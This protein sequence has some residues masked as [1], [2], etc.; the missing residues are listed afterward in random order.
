MRNWKKVLAYLILCAGAFVTFALLA[1]GRGLIVAVPGI[2]M[3]VFAVA[4]LRFM[5]LREERR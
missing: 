2:A 3:V 1:A 5:R 4:W